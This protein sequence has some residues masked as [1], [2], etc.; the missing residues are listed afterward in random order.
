VALKAPLTNSRPTTGA[1]KHGRVKIFPM[2][3][4]NYKS[5]KQMIKHEKKENKK[6]DYEGF[7]K[8]AYGKRKSCS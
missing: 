3:N 8:A 6:K 1:A 7:G 2:K 5:R 4:E